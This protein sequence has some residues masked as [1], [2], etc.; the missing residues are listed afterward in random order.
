MVVAPGSE[1]WDFPISAA[2][3]LVNSDVGTLTVTRHPKTSRAVLKFT[4][5][6]GLVDTD[7]EVLSEGMTLI[8][9]DGTIL[10]FAALKDEGQAY[11]P[12]REGGVP[13]QP[14]DIPAG[15]YYVAPGLFAAGT[16]VRLLDRVRAGEQAVL[17][18]AGVPK[19]TAVEGQT[20]N[21]SFDARAAYTAINGSPPIELPPPPSPAPP[22]P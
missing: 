7:M 2:Q 4:N 22:G 20:A 18:A 19:F 3:T 17:D 6:V 15:D 9:T 5:Y 10:T 13:L 12:V 8:R 16:A 14:I 11:A 1:Y 21:F